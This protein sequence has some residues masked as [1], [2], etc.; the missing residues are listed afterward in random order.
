[1]NSPLT[2]LAFICLFISAAIFT[3]L[4]SGMAFIEMTLPGGLPVGNALVAIGLSSFAF[5]AV[6]LSTNGAIQYKFSRVTFIIT[7]FWLPISIALAQ[8]LLLNFGSKNGEIWLIFTLTIL[9]LTFASWLWAFVVWLIRRRFN[10]KR[11][12]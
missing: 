5:S 11:P 4:A 6:L 10:I 12:E 9:A 2:L 1:M 7:L 3:G 8:N